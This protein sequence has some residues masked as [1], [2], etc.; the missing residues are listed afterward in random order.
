MPIT[1]L[2][3]RPLEHLRLP[4]CLS[5][6]AQWREAARQSDRRTI[7]NDIEAISV[8][9][10]NY[11]GGTRRSY[12]AGLEKLLLWCVFARGH[13]LSE[14]KADEIALYVGFLVKIHPV[15][16]WVSLGLRRRDEPDWKP[17]AKDS[18]LPNSI[19]LLLRQATIYFKWASGYGLANQGQLIMAAGE[20]ITPEGLPVMPQTTRMF[21]ERIS[22]RQWVILRSVLAESDASE[23]SHWSFRLVTE[24]VYYMGFLVQSL[25]NIRWTD[26]KPIRADQNIVTWMIPAPK[27][28]AEFVFSIGSL[29]ATISHLMRYRDQLKINRQKT[30]WNDTLVS[31]SPQTFHLYLQRAS[32]RAAEKA[33]SLGL[34]TDAHY[35][36]RLTIPKLRGGG[37]DA[38]FSSGT[39]QE[40]SAIY[41]SSSLNFYP[42]LRRK[43]RLGGLDGVHSSQVLGSWI[44]SEENKVEKLIL[45]LS[46]TLS[47]GARPL[48]EEGTLPVN[49]N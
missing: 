46:S 18:L 23:F 7:T 16:E 9:A 38:A 6:V 29:T 28:R 14:L 12:L 11:A 26:L 42:E 5:G 10:S 40:Y 37:V 41:G 21:D 34:E 43:A 20:L 33:L 39:R 25:E 2:D 31:R 15:D 17:F 30:H 45:Q 3:I 44:R 24:L 19:G 22:I 32:A 35:L 48:P 13:S 36:A 49:Q 1:T 27:G 8:W 4:D 47:V